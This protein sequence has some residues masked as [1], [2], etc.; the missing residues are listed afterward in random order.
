MNRMVEIGGNT[1]P[2]RDQL[3]ALGGRCE[4]RGSRWVWLVPEAR[5]AEAKRIVAEAAAATGG[6]TARRGGGRAG[7][8]C[9]TCRARINYGRYCGKCEYRR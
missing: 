2:V 3:R 4:R 5:A 1:Y 6:G 9:E 8:V 7:H